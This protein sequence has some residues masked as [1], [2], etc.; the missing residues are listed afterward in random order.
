MSI[1]LG[2]PHRKS[3]T[4]V[5]QPPTQPCFTQ[6]CAYLVAFLEGIQR[7]LHAFLT[8]LDVMDCMPA[9]AFDFD[10]FPRLTV[11]AGQDANIGWL[12]T[13]FREKHGVMQND[14]E[15]GTRW[16]RRCPALFFLRTLGLGSCFCWTRAH[17]RCGE[18]AK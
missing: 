11:P 12:S 4:Y 1:L 9:N 13:A 17:Y 14:L 2:G 8:D 7:Y 16:C 6:R 3:D 5:V 10:D 15:K 18:F